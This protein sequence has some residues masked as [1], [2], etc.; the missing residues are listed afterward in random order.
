[1]TS[2]CTVQTNCTACMSDLYLL[3]S[4]GTKSISTTYSAA[5]YIPEICTWNAGNILLQCVNMQMNIM[6]P[7]VPEK[8]GR[9]E[10]QG[11]IMRNT[12]I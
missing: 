3:S 1:M 12:R 10:L 4:T 8:R 6:S 9:N 7:D 11:K 5:G 2:Y